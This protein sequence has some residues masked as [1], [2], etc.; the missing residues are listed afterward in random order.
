MSKKLIAIVTGMQH[1]GTTY[2]NNVINSHP[3]IMSG[4]ECGILLK[5]LKN[6]ENVKPF[7]DWL[8]TDGTHFGLP[9]NYL[10]EIKNMNYVQVYEYIQLNKGSKNNSHYQHLLRKAP[11][12]TDKTPQYIYQLQNIHK[13]TLHFNIPI[14]IV[15]KKYDEIYYSWVIKRK[16]NFSDFIINMQ[17]CVESLKFLSIHKPNN[18]YLFEYKDL[19]NNKKKYNRKIMEIIQ[20]Y[21]K[22]IPFENLHE[23]KF[24]FKIRD[25][26]KYVKDTNSTTINVDTDNHKYKEIYNHLIDLLKIK[27]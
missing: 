25:P 15:L 14:I 17:L 11:N 2:L 4:F 20:I 12:F 22:K 19:I 9:D 26:K 5:N 3:R 1:S 16:I 13:K 27:L 7:S 6:F 24:K 10:E 23:A 8:K 18:I 21:N